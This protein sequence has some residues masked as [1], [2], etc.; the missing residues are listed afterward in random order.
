MLRQHRRSLSA[1]IS[2]SFYFCSAIH[3]CTP[4]GLL[5]RI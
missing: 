1:Y 2:I 4:F 3:P 5:W